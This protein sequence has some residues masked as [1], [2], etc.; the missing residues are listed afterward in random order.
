MS[1]IA[2][3]R[4]LTHVLRRFIQISRAWPV[5]VTSTGDG[6]VGY[7][8]KYPE[9]RQWLSL[10]IIGVTVSTADILCSNEDSY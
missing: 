7:R 8:M 2:I 5:G 6:L 4:Q 10:S 1:A 3:F 9:T